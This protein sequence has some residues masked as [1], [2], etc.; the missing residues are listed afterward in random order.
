MVRNAE[1]GLRGTQSVAYHRGSR[2]GDVGALGWRGGGGGGI[3]GNY[4]L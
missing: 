2:R 4:C 3:G 1:M